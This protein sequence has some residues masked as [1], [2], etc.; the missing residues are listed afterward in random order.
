MKLR[1]WL[2]AAAA[3]LMML[4]FA[5]E[6]VLALQSAKEGLS[7]FLAVVLPSLLPFMVCAHLFIESGAAAAAGRLLNRLMRPLFAC[8]GE[9]AFALT[10]GLLAGYPTGARLALDLKEQGL[11]TAEDAARTGLLASSCGPVFMLGAVGAGLLMNPAA[12]WLILLSHIAAVLVTGMVFSI[13]GN[14]SSAQPARIAGAG[15]VKPVMEA[16]GESIKKT[17][18]TLWTVGGYIIIFSVL[19]ALMKH[20]NILAPVAALA[21]PLLRLIGLEPSLAAPLAIGAIEMTNGCNAIAAA[22]ASLAS[23]CAAM[24]LLVSFGGFC[25]QAQSMLFLAKVG[26]PFWKFL[27]MKTVQAAIAFAACRVL[28]LL[29]VFNTVLCMGSIDMPGYSVASA[30]LASTAYTAGG[31]LLFA[32]LAFVSGR[33]STRG[34]A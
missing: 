7:L 4:G 9:S 30:L 32:G 6:P 19:T 27:L 20:Y 22:N 15:E 13:G 21:A 34:S 8:P 18:L 12:G 28:A 16:F 26:L 24:S 17:V 11:I 14:R 3:V 33:A 23:Q 31:M 29:P 2:M 5:L 25:I 10:A 1:G